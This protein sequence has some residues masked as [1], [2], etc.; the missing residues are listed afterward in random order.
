MTE[1]DFTDLARYEYSQDLAFCSH[2]HALVMFD[3][4]IGQ[5]VDARMQPY[6]RGGKHHTAPEILIR[7]AV[8]H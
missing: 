6:C 8:S 2:C 7:P 5:W 4:F 3:D 1:A